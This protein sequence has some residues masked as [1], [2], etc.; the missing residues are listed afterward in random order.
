VFS[1]EP[2]CQGLASLA[3]VWDSPVLQSL[4]SQIGLARNLEQVFKISPSIR[5]RFVAPFFTLYWQRA[6]SSNPEQFRTSAAY[7]QKVYI[8]VASLLPLVRVKK[9]LNTMVFCTKLSLPDDLR[10]W[11]DEDS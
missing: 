10:A 8:E 6:I 1:F 11:L 5:A 2:R 4:V 7:T 9:L 3:S